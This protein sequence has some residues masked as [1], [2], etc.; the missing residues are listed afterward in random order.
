MVYVSLQLE[1][2]VNFL[3]NGVKS[4]TSVLSSAVMIPFKAFNSEKNVDQSESYTIQKNINKSINKI[5][6]QI[7]QRACAKVFDEE[8]CFYEIAE[9]MILLVW[10]YL[11]EFSML[12][13]S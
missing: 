10:E 3:E 7:S 4:I 8:I 12:I 5:K 6:K 1:R 11:R 2:R 9:S 13:L